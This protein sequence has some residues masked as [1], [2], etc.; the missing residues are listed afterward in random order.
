LIKGGRVKS[1][2]EKHPAS[3]AYLLEILHAVQ[4]AEPRHY[5][6][7]AA[8]RSVA[9]YVNVPLVDVIS[10]ATFYSMYSLEPRG[11]HI[12]RICA[13]PPCQ[14]AGAG[15]LVDILEERLG[16]GVGETTQDGLFTLETTSCLGSCGGAPAMMIDNELYGNLTEE[17][18]A[19]VLEQVGRGGTTPTQAEPHGVADI[20]LGSTMAT[21]EKPRIVLQNCG[22]VD[23]NSLD[24]AVSAGAYRAMGKVVDEGIRPDMVID[25]VKRSGLRGRGGA[26]FPTGLKWSYTAKDE[27]VYVVCN[28]DEGEP[29]TF[30][31]RLILEGDPHRLIEGMMLAGYAVG[32]TMG[33]VYIR[34][35][36]AL[37]IERMQT[38]IGAAREAG[39]LGEGILDS[40]FS[41]DIEIRKGAGS[42]VCGEETALIESIEGKRGF[43]RIKPPYPGAVGVW[44]RPTVVNNVETLANVPPIVLNGAD[45][46]RS[47]GTD[48]SPGTKVFLILGDV[49]SPGLIEAEMGT[50][51]RT[52]IEEY[53]GGVRG[54]KRFKAALLGGAAGAFVDEAAL[55]VAMDFDS[56]AEHDAVLGSG[57]VL[58]LGEEASVVELLW[59]ILRF[60]E[61]ESCGQCVP[62]RLGTARLAEIV[63]RI[64]SGDGSADDIELLHQVATV[65]RDTSLCPLG[66]SP[67]LPIETALDRFGDE[68]AKRFADGATAPAAE[69]RGK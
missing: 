54:G 2:L 37:S 1:L 30:K 39:L 51:L 7:P 55:D 20:I 10:T 17:S 67:I 12:I 57:A 19:T 62:C 59:G 33:Y 14:L 22:A 63:G 21:A 56:L 34:G 6:S 41:F 4:D 29:G 52:I 9:D 47:F 50:S 44:D 64:A 3:P 8:L 25:E 61:H 18:L 60:F 45:W 40:S 42:Y 32:A 66:Q 28:A 15:S 36:Y 38:A 26:G 27:Q 35:E 16:I 68:F 49:E 58:V 43:P 31:D 53:G 65:M 69:Q 46:F 11:R 23:P 24:E 13:S 48:S 5:L